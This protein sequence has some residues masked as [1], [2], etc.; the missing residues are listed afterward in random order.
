LKVFWGKGF[1]AGLHWW[2]IA[3]ACIKS[4]LDILAFVDLSKETRFLGER[5]GLSG[6]GWGTLVPP[7]F[8]GG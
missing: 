8:K 1:N 5:L 3:P 2:N 7:F 6:M 4:I